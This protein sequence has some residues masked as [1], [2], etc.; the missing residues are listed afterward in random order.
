V[1]IASGPACHLAQDRRSRCRDGAENRRRLAQGQEEENK[2]TPTEREQELRSLIDEARRALR[3][4]DNAVLRFDKDPAVPALATAAEKWHRLRE[5]IEQL[6]TDDL[7]PELRT[8]IRK[9]DDEFQSTR[10]KIALVSGGQSSEFDAQEEALRVQVEETKAQAKTDEMG[11]EE[12]LAEIDRMREASR[13]TKEF[14]AKWL[15]DRKLA[16]A[17]LTEE[18][19][20]E[21]DAVV[22]AEFKRIYFRDDPEQEQNNLPGWLL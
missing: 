9:L 3:S 15:S 1:F 14:A 12:R 8:K 7:S 10:A 13:L 17:S 11:R 6:T 18:Q 4:Y 21:F 2:V 22:L 16:E 5:Q 20:A 19:R